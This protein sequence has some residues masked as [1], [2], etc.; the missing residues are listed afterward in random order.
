MKATQ[1]QVIKEADINVK[2]LCNLIKPDV[3]RALGRS[4]TTWE[5]LKYTTKPERPMIYYVKVHIGNGECLHLKMH[6]TT[7]RYPKQLELQGISIGMRLNT[8]LE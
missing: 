2:H 6:K 4:L 5:P 7:P 1:T 3:E 8:P